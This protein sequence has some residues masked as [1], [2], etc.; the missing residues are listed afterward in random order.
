MAALVTSESY[1]YSKLFAS[2]LIVQMY[3]ILSKRFRKLVIHNWKL[4]KSF[5]YTL[6]LIIIISNISNIGCRQKNYGF[7][8]FF[9]ES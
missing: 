7:A 8:D 1:I 9:L 6:L 3:K 4:L 2:I 5:P